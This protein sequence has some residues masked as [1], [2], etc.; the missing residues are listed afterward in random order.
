M[1]KIVKLL[2]VVAIVGSLSACYST[3]KEIDSGTTSKLIKGETT[4]TQVEAA[5]GK[6][7]TTT[8]NSDGTVYWSYIYGNVD[9]NAATYIPIVG[10]F[11]GGAKTETQTLVITFDSNNIVT[12]WT[13]SDSATESG[14]VFNN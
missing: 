4:S 7:Q 3:G 10:L 9:I 2:T 8:K 5:L 6:P 1:K 11:A 14:S 12:D 13:Q